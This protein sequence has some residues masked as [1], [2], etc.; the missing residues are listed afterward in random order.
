MKINRVDIRQLKNVN[1]LFTLQRICLPSDN[2]YD[3][4]TGFW[5]AATDA[6]S[7]DIAFAGLVYSSRWSDCGYLCRAGVVPSSRGQGIQK[8]LI[9]VRIRQA[10]AVGMK[11]L[12]T[13]T[14]NNPASS[15]SL[16]S[17]GFKLFDPSV[18]WGATGTLYFRLKLE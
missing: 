5:W 14:Y 13:D 16:I 15:N 2:P 10:K 3:T 1:R 8:K 7:R 12:I 17:C 9:R 4:T 6:S 18:P 11:W